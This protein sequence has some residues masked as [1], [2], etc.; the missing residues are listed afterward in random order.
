FEKMETVTQENKIP[1][2]A[3]RTRYKYYEFA[4]ISFKLTNTPAIFINYI[5]RIFHPF[6]NK[7]V[8]IFIDNILIYSKIT[9]KHEKHL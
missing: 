3:F 6:L 1:K 2:I 9:K 4:I 8:I 5:N 7:F